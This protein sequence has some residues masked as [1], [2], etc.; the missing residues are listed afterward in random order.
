MQWET[1]NQKIHVTHFIA[2]M[3][4][5]DGLEL[6]LQ[7]L[8]G[9]PVFLHSFLQKTRLLVLNWEGFCPLGTFGNLGKIFDCQNW[10]WGVEI[11]TGI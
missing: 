8:Q 4:Y 10:G 5:C 3:L 9:L 7:Y 11:A 6:N 2:D 1:K